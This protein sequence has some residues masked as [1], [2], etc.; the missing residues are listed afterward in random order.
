MNLLFFMVLLF[1]SCSSENRLEEEVVARVNESVLTKEA[2]S[3]LVGDSPESRKIYTHAI[4]RWVEKILLY[5][6]AISVGLNK[7]RGLVEQKE[8]FYKDLLVSSYINTRTD[9]PGF[10]IKNEV[11]QYYIKNKKSFARAGD[12]VVVKHFV[13]KTLKEAKSIKKELNKNKKSK[14]IEEIIKKHKPTTRTL[15]AELLKDS[16][17]GFVFGGNVGDVLGP[18]KH[19]EDYHVFQILKKN[20]KGSLRGL[21]LVHDEIYQRLY[22]KK[23]IDVLKQTIDSL[24]ARSDVFISQEFFR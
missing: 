19:G 15:R 3:Q 21:E 4:N 10:P 9:K 7:D 6:A 2:L 1:F 20:K 13:S 22:K 5:N 14:K 24:Y 8:S 16:L 23:E 17:V 12:E 11:S 18:K